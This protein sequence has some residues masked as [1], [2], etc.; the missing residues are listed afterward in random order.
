MRILL[1]F[2]SLPD[3]LFQ[4]KEKKTNERKGVK[5]KVCALSIVYSFIYSFIHLF[6]YSFIHLFIYS[7]IHLFIHS[8]I[9]PSIHPYFFIEDWKDFELFKTD[10]SLLCTLYPA[11]NL[12]SLSKDGEVRCLV[13]HL[14]VTRPDFSLVRPKRLTPFCP[15]F[16]CVL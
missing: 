2:D 16:P 9:H 8:F 6:I 13:R 1:I 3:S 12:V 4:P 10:L 5:R 14:E 11:P 7:F 15:L